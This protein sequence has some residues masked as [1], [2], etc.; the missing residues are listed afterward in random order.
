MFGKR[1]NEPLT[2]TLENAAQHLNAGS[3]QLGKTLTGDLRIGITTPRHNPGDTGSNDSRRTG[4]GPATM[5]TGLQ[6]DIKRGSLGRSPGLT[7]GKELGV[8]LSGGR[9]KSFT[10][11]DVIPD[12]DCPDCRIRRSAPLGAARQVKGTAHIAFVL[13]LQSNNGSVSHRCVPPL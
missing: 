5:A 7:Q 1:G 13:A 11:N 4:P 8:R 12:N 9:M 3:L 6:R 10:D 2:L